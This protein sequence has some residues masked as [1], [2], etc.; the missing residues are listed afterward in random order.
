MKAPKV[1]FLIENHVPISCYFLCHF[2]SSGFNAALTLRLFRHNLLSSAL[3]IK[4]WESVEH[5][6]GTHLGDDR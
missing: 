1:T 4:L 2:K 5:Q 3:D 6:E